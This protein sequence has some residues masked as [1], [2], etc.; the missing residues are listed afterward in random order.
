MRSPIVYCGPMWGGKTEALISRLVRAELQSIPVMALQPRCNDR[1]GTH[2]LKAH[3]GASFPAVP[4]QDGD[5]LLEH[6]RRRDPLVV[7]IDEFFMIPGA[8]DAVRQLMEQQRKI[9][10]ATLDMDAEAVVWEEVGPLLGLAEE[11]HKCPAV[12]ARCKNDAYY[13]FKRAGA[14]EGRVLVGAGEVYEPRCYP[15]FV[16]GQRAKA[17][18]ERDSLYSPRQASGR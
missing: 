10:I 6:V 3:S 4:I 2:D 12:C 18:E 17:A 1:Y 14:P 13:T 8:L 9:V 15:C 11:V 5:E 7:G 16:A